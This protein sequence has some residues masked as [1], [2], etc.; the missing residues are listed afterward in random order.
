M[1]PGG[2]STGHCSSKVERQ[3][4]AIYCTDE[5]EQLAPDSASTFLPK[6]HLPQFGDVNTVDTRALAGLWTALARI[7]YGQAPEVLASIIPSGCSCVLPYTCQGIKSRIVGIP[8]HCSPRSA[9]RCCTK[10]ADNIVHA[11]NNIRA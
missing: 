2:F 4:F 10:Y 9:R 5:L 6:S 8:F 1:R 3:K 11:K 7:S